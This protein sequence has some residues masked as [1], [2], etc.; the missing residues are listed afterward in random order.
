MIDKPWFDYSGESTVDLLR[1][2][3]TY[4]LDSLNCAFDKALQD[5]E[6]DGAALTGTELVVLAVEALQ[7]EVNNGGFHQFFVNSSREYA[8]IIAESLDLI[9]ATEVAS[10][11]SEAIAALR[12]PEVT[13]DAVMEAAE[14]AIVEDDQEMLERL[15]N[16]DQ[17]FYGI[18]GLDEQLFGFIRANA[19]EIR[20]S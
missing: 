15:E 4:R 6:A 11:A 3:E 13:P 7:R 2:G 10:L 18:A 20:L 12:I 9:G 1:L 17:R 16:C 8:P 5:K 14:R 19:A